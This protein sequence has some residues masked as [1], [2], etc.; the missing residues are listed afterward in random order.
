VTLN[1]RTGTITGNAAII[2]AGANG[3]IDVYATNN[4]DVVIDVN[5]YFGV[6]GAG[7]LS[8][9]TM[10]PCRV[11][12]TRTQPASPLG[13]PSLSAGTRDFDLSSGGC[14]VPAANAYAM[15]ATVI[16]NGRLGWLTLWPLG[17]AQPVA[18]TLNSV[19]GVITGNAP[20][21]PAAAG[22]ISAYATGKADLIL[23]LGGYFVP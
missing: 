11:V 2:P 13:A 23:D 22:V 21:V 6:P 3:A 20:V 18:S 9:V 5:G 17:S 12:D 16:P 14:G 10:P 4:T 1:A 8:F 19:D 7:G 15:N